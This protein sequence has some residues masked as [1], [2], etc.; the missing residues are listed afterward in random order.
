[1]KP[2]A[3]LLTIVRATA[4][5]AAFAARYPQQDIVIAEPYEKGRDYRGEPPLHPSTVF[6]LVTRAAGQ[7]VPV[8]RDARAVVQLDHA[9][10]SRLHLVM[11]WAG[12]GWKV[13]DRSSNGSWMNEE[14][15]PGQQPVPAA[16]GATLRL[17][18]AMV[19]RV[20]TPEG[21]WEFARA[22]AGAPPPMVAPKPPVTPP[23]ADPRASTWRFAAVPDSLLEP[24]SSDELSLD[25]DGNRGRG[26]PP[27]PPPPPA[28]PTRTVQRPAV[29]PPPVAAGDDV[30]IEFDLD[31][32]DGKGGFA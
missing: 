21:L 23:P 32:S 19:V 11:A 3:E 10:V 12:Q 18:R 6:D 8:G 26:A 13:M 25:F 15:L 28:P 7:P 16:Y 2:I 14:R 29:A 9:A 5:P 20:F 1:M 17:G 22:A 24:D 31:F 27:P 30:E 4:S